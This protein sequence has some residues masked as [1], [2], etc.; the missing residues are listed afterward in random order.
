[1]SFLYLRYLPIRNF[2][3]SLGVVIGNVTLFGKLDNGR[4]RKSSISA[5]IR[6]RAVYPL[7]RLLFNPDYGAARRM[8]ERSSASL[9]CSVLSAVFKDFILKG[10]VFILAC[11]SALLHL[12]LEHVTICKIGKQYDALRSMFMFRGDFLSAH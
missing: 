11:K 6:R 12:E 8:G 4:R 10:A 1:M 2:I 9:T 7:Y 3:V 5:H